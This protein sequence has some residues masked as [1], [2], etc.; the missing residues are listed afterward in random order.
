M[1]VRG[2]LF[3]RELEQAN[4]VEKARAGTNIELVAPRRVGKTSLLR[5]VERDLVR[6]PLHRLGGL[7]QPG[8]KRSGRSPRPRSVTNP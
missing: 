4:L 6:L 7:H 5:A 2:C 1:G 8:G 3:G